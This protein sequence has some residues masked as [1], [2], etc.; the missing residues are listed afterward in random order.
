MNWYF[1]KE[2]FQF[3]YFFVCGILQAIWGKSHSTCFCF[4]FLFSLFFRWK[5]ETEQV[6]KKNAFLFQ[7]WDVKKNFKHLLVKLL[8]FFSISKEKQTSNKTLYTGQCNNFC[9]V[10]I[11][12]TKR[13]FF[14]FSFEQGSE[15]ETWQTK[16]ILPRKQTWPSLWKEEKVGKLRKQKKR[17]KKFDY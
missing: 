14:V 3:A 15:K 10:I 8:N 6:R 1:S 9:L 4:L 2:E 13:N 5:K 16:V 17:Q 12:L 7:M 11:Y